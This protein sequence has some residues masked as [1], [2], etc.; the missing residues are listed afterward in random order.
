MNRWR[1]EGASALLPDGRN[2]SGG[3]EGKRRVLLLSPPLEL[4][5]PHLDLLPPP[6]SAVFRSPGSPPPIAGLAA[7][8]SRPAG[9]GP[10]GRLGAS[11]ADGV[12]KKVRSERTRDG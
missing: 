1:D 12:R 7:T 10:I 2:G 5:L 3:Q 9:R 6:L 11:R 4:H 8:C